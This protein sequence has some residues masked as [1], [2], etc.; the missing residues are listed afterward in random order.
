MS[1]PK[2]VAND[3]DVGTFIKAVE[4]PRRRAD[5]A[6]LLELMRERYG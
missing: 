1:K 4:N 6:T 2:T 3:A 5:A